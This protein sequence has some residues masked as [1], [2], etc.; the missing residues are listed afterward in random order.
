MTINY[1]GDTHGGRRNQRRAKEGR[2]KG[3]GSTYKPQLNVYDVASRGRSVRMPHEG[4]MVQ[5]LSTLEG[6][7]FL[8]LAWMKQ[9]SEIREQVPLPLEATLAIADELGILHPT[10]PQDGSPA[11]MTTDLVFIFTQFGRSVECARAV[12]TCA[13]LDPRLADRAAREMQ[14]INV[15]AKLEIEKVYWTR[16]RADWRIFCDLDDDRTRAANICLFLYNDALDPMRGPVFW[17]QALD[18]TARTVL[19]GGDDL[20]EDLGRKLEAEEKLTRADFM[21]CVLHLCA[22]RIFEFD[23]RLVFAPDLRACEFAPGQS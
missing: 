21:A 16:Q 22:T 12:K 10:I 1:F 8:H 23:M 17:E 9:V 19:R 2:G 15:L 13:D 4:R 6:R 14:L 7:C 3:L 20:L 11:V 5:L 18:L